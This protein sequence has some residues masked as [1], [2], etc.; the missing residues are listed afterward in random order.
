MLSIKRNIIKTFL[1]KSIKHEIHFSIC[2][3]NDR[4]NVKNTIQKYGEKISTGKISR[5]W[6]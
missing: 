4:I 2:V 5:M 3:K 6:L 1:K